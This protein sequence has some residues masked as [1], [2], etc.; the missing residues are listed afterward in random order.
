MLDWLLTVGSVRFRGSVVSSD[1]RSILIDDVN[2]PDV[3]YICDGN[4]GSVVSPACC[5]ILS[6]DEN[7]PGAVL[8]ICDGE[9]ARQCSLV[10][11]R[12]NA[13]SSLDWG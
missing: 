3:L 10:N 11:G 12:F 6:D 9:P 1:E 7:C 8:Y 13:G 5:S 4:L 2:C